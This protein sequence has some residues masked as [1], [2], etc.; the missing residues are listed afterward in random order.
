[1]N[2]QIPK[3]GRRPSAGPRFDYVLAVPITEAQRE[4][5]REEATRAGFRSLAEYVRRNKLTIDRDVVTST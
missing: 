5:L 4:Q 1:V 3:M 2:T